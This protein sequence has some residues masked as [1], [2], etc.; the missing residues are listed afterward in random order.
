MYLESTCHIQGCKYLVDIV[1]YQL[2]LY[3]TRN[4]FESLQRC[5]EKYESYQ[6]AKINDNTSRQKTNH[7][8][9]AE[10]SK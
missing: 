3:E 7:S 5:K 10:L 9:M 6:F 1:H 2:F 4:I 8:K